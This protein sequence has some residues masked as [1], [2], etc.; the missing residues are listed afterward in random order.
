MLVVLKHAVNLLKV[1]QL[2]KIVSWKKG[3][4]RVFETSNKP[5]YIGLVVLILGILLC[6]F[7]ISNGIDYVLSYIVIILSIVFFFCSIAIYK[8][9]KREVNIMQ[10]GWLLKI[11]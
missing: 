5:K 8:K 10:D 4:R 6:V 11:F 3:K 9:H 1:I 2:G 7:V